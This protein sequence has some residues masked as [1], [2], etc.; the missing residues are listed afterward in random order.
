MLIAMAVYD[1]V[2]N[3]RSGCTER[4]LAS[5]FERVDWQR[6]RLVIVDNGSTDPRTRELLKE[7]ADGVC[8][9]PHVIQSPATMLQNETNLGTA[10]AINRAWQLR[11]PGEHCVKMDND[12]VVHQN[13]WPDLMEEVFARAP[14]IGICGL[15][16]KDLEERPDADCEWYRS[17][18]VMLPQKKGERWIVVEQVN[19]V[20]GTCQGY[21]SALLD[22]IGYLYQLDGLYGFDDLLAAVRSRVAGFGSVFLP[23]IE[24]DHVDNCEP[25]YTHWKS[26]YASAL[27]A[28]YNEVRAGYESGALPIY[29]EP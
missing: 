17:R 14:N 26:Q 29:C 7:A 15:K 4:T 28:K 12:V 9:T 22:K 11:Q 23:H 3:Q 8:R 24:I 13:G 18:L 27:M 20:I 16:R 19:H 1:T 10:K 21:N 2:E 6:H 25:G 5:L